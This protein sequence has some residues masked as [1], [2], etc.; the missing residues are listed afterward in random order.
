MVFNILIILQVNRF[1]I[2]VVWGL[3]NPHIFLW[4]CILALVLM[5]AFEKRLQATV[6][7]WILWYDWL[8]MGNICCKWAYLL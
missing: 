8:S 2:Q 4:L 7:P 6:F 1:K 3:L 5:G